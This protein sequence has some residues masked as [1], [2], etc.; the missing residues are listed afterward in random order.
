M[1]CCAE[2]GS[3]RGLCGGEIRPDAHPHSEQDL[4]SHAE[5]ERGPELVCAS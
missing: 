3:G 5:P 1:A 4:S 2:G